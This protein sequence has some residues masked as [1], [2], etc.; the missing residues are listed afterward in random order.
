MIFNFNFN[1]A[2]AEELR[3]IN[4]RLDTL[5]TTIAE[6]TATI[7]DLTVKT[8]KIGEETRALLQKIADLTALVE[9]GNTT[10]AEFD[11]ALA[12]LKAQVD[13]VDGLV[14]DLAP[15]PTPQP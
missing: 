13:V 5:M 9:A 11:A 8:T 14:P 2:S 4:H 1:G 10:G 7:N 15:A 6:A 3:A 12:A